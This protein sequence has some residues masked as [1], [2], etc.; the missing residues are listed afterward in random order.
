MKVSKSYAEMMRATLNE[1]EAL[2]RPDDSALQ[3]VERNQSASSSEGGKMTPPSTNGWDFFKSPQ[4]SVL[5]ATVA[6]LVCAAV[7]YSTMGG[8]VDALR[9]EVKADVQTLSQRNDVRFDQIGSKFDGIS[10]K[11]DADSREIRTLILNQQRQPQQH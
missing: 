3:D 8:K 2:P 6:V 11:M 10:A 1:Y 7:M 4:F 5:A 9:M